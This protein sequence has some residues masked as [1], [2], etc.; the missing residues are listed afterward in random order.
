MNTGRYSVKSL[1][2]SSEIEQIV[3]PE[4]QRDYVWKESNVKGL[5]QSIL[6]HFDKKTS[7]QLDMVER[8]SG[9][10]VNKEIVS[11]LSEEYTRL[12][13]STRIGFIYAYHSP[14]YPGKF[15]LIDG[16]Q[17][18]TTIFLVLLASYKRADCSESYWKQY[19]SLRRPKID[20][21][22]REITHDFM[23]DFIEYETG[24]AYE[25]RNISFEESNK[26]FDYYRIDV[27]TSR[28][29]EN[30]RVIEKLLESNRGEREERQYYK[31]LINYLENYI[32]FNYFDT[33]I[34]E[35]G[36]RL[37]LYM[38]SRGEDL[39]TH[40]SLRPLLVGRSDEKQEAGKKWERWQTFFWLHRGSNHN[41][42]AGFNEFLKWCT[43]LHICLSDHPKLESEGK[44]VKDKGNY[45]RVEKTDRNKAESQQ[46]KIR[47]YQEE[48]SGFDISFIDNVFSATERLK[49]IL[50]GE[51]LYHYIP[52]EW[53][54]EINNTR[55][56]PC[57]LS[58]LAY[59]L[60]NPSA[61]LTDIRRVGMFIKNCMYYDT[62]KKNPEDATIL[63]INAIQ[64]LKKSKYTDIADLRH[65]SGDVSK[66]IYT[67]TDTLKRACYNTMLRSQW[68]ESIWKITEDDEF[69]S[70]LAGDIRCLF[71]WSGYDFSKFERYYQDLKTR[72]IQVVKNS[73]Q[74]SLHKDLLKYGDF[75]YQE[76]SGLG[77]PR[78]Y[79]LKYESEWCKGINNHP[80]IRT[81]LKQFLDNEKPGCNGTLYKFFVDGNESILGY[82]E[83]M[84]YLKDDETPTH[85]ILPRIYQLSGDNY[86]ELM[87]QWVH[88]RFSDSWVYGRDTVV[89]PFEIT[90]ISGK[91]EIN[92]LGGWNEDKKFYLDIKYDWNSRNPFWSFKIASRGPSFTNHFNQLIPDWQRIP[93][94]ET[95]MD[96]YHRKNALPD[97]I[98]SSVH[99]RVQAVEDFVTQT[100]AQICS[101]SPAPSSRP[102]TLYG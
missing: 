80:N 67:E 39:S 69:S 10:P 54:S 99:D 40:E 11:V 100:F 13:H 62:N 76:G 12:V 33:N 61:G 101:S 56:Y 85:I 78:H 24:L 70:F 73:D 59:L 93:N 66:S 87:V 46:K 53:L 64:S 17:R 7:L 14:D 27:T 102:A 96:E 18:L 6:D 72:I 44:S 86:R 23:V 19:F 75:E 32:E 22:V 1:F 57:L 84:E 50:A 4:I 34:S 37:Y 30:Y 92:R 20:Y 47:L 65:V 60:H 83:Y 25:D 31:S 5:M 79:L 49:G 35:Q 97:N 45:V 63:A 2:Q 95:G 81:I 98:N 9:Q 71:E 26:F 38:N 21:L 94:R 36:E 48:N 58:C 43:I 28:L 15:F 51:T 55:D 41:A 88:Q 52:S 89:L 8:V 90:S 42:D 91:D 74:I 68:E 16:Q 29:L 77:M 82:T 3:I